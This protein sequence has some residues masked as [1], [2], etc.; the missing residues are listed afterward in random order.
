MQLA[1]HE[2]PFGSNSLIHPD[3]MFLLAIFLEGREKYWINQLWELYL[4]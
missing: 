4:S 2:F 3:F 1:Q